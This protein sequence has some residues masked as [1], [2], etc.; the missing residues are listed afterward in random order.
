MDNLVSM[1]DECIEDMRGIVFSWS[2]KDPLT[3]LFPELL[4]HDHHWGTTRSKNKPKIANIKMGTE[5][6]ATATEFKPLNE[7]VGNR[8][9]GRVKKGNRSSIPM[10]LVEIQNTL[11]KPISSFDSQKGQWRKI[12]PPPLLQEQQWRT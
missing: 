5:L 7:K 6:S 12:D 10:P 11:M 1:V 8:V 3:F 4:R 2:Y 9:E